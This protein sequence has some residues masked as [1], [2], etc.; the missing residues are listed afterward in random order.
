MESTVSLNSDQIAFYR[1]NGYLAIPRLMPLDEVEVVRGIYDRLFA[2]R[3]G[4][5]AGDQFDLAGTDEEGVEAT[6]PQI[7]GPS[8]Y[9]PELL[10][11]RYR[12]YLS[13]VI[14]QLL[15]PAGEV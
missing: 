14:K 7:L 15:G 9:A 5:E 3:A 11:G 6:L 8:R 2:A 10:E 1:E 4:R 12:A 13:H